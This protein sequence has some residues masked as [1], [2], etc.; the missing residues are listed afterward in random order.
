[1]FIIL[2]SCVFGVTAVHLFEFKSIQIEFVPT[3]REFFLF[4]GSTDYAY[5]HQRNGK[6]ELWL[7]QNTSNYAV[8]TTKNSSTLLFEW[9]GTTAQI[10][11]YT[12]ESTIQEGTFNY[13]L[14][15]N[16]E[17]FQCEILSLY[18]GNG[19]DRQ[20]EPQPLTYKCKPPSKWLLICTITVSISV[21]S[22]LLLYV[23]NE[24]I[25]TVLGSSISWLSRRRREILFSSK[26]S[27][28]QSDEEESFAGSE[29][30][31]S[32]YITQEIHSTEKISENLDTC[33]KGSLADRST[34]SS[35]V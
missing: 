11:G 21:V 30:I 7:T 13:P 20:V 1:M 4:N 3:C 14:K 31:R 9:N 34:G 22:F 29:Q 16:Y 2:L 23:K 5:F 18:A 33:T 15:F 24:S 27:L 12:M 19:I 8:Y 28:P 32:I 10:N 25:K 6:F 35:E 17:Q 26:E